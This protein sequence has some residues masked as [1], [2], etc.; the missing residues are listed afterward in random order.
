M[1]KA[2]KNFGRGV[3]RESVQEKERTEGIN[4]V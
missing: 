1:K 4:T 2:L 3:G